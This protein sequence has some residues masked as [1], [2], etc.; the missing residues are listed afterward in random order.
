MIE[1]RRMFREPACLKAA[2]KAVNSNGP[3]TTIDVLNVSQSGMFLG[4]AS[5][6]QLG[7]SVGSEIRLRLFLPG[8]VG[9]VSVTGTV[10]W[11]G[12]SERHGRMGFGVEFCR[13][14]PILVAFLKASQ[15][16]TPPQQP[17]SVSA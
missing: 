15:A 9:Y 14:H 17:D 1:K 6:K 11:R 16:S 2:W 12:L 5:S 7:T 3:L 8:G 13:E 10:R 4:I